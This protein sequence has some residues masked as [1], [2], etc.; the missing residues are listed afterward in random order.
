MRSAWPPAMRAS[1]IR[2][3]LLAHEG[4]RRPRD[5]VHDRDVAG[6]EVGELRQEQGRPDIAEEALVQVGAGIGRVSEPGQD[7]AVDRVVALAAAGGDDHL[8]LGLAG[9]VVLE[10][11]RV[12]REA[13]RVAAE[14]LPR[15]H[16]ALVALLRDLPVPFERRDG[17]DR[18]IGETLAPERRQAACRERLEMRRQPL[19]LRRHETRAG[20]HDRAT[21][22]A[23]STSSPMLRARPRM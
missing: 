15:L 12:E 4:P 5:A 18:V 19:A 13:G 6:R 16:L 14:A 23:V 21:H 9:R 10:A 1:A 22:Q 8:G 17:M 20:H 11:G 3:A 7:L 2:S